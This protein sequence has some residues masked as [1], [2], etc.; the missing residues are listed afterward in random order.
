MQSS[1]MA[2]G[3]EDSQP[4]QLGPYATSIELRNKVLLAC[5]LWTQFVD[6]SVTFSC[7]RITS[8][9]HGF[10]SSHTERAVTETTGH[11]S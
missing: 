7:G 8:R 5:V 2:G 11:M 9:R 4:I 6:I 10:M 3:R 1:L